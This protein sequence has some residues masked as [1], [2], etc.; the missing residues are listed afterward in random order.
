M[1]EI[2]VESGEE[3][4]LPGF[5]GGVWHFFRPIKLWKLVLCAIQ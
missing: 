3:L 2:I 4:V 5:H 1:G